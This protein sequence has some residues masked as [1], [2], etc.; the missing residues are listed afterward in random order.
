MN[1]SLCFLVASCVSGQAPAPAVL[2]APA[3]TVVPV[4]TGCGSGCGN[5]CCA[6]QAPDCQR[7]GFGERLRGLF[8]RLRHHGD[9]C[10]DSCGGCG[11]GNGLAMGQTGAPPLMTLLPAPKEPTVITTSAKSSSPSELKPEYAKKVA[12]AEDYTWV[13]GQLYYVNTDGGLWV[14]RYAP[15]D[16]EDRF[17]GSVVLA[18][19]VNMDGFRDGDL[20]TVHGEVLNTGRASKHLGG[21]LY[22]TTSAELIERVPGDVGQ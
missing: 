10:C 15:V 13:T 18:A 6:E 19:A 8:G 21:A 16:K 20:V 17:G 2:P 5:P 11:C 9:T 3:G 7:H 14:V 12:N 4:S 22:R 1:L